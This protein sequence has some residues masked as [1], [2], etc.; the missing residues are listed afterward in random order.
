MDDA[1]RVKLEIAGAEFPSFL[2]QTRIDR[3]TLRAV[4]PERAL[5]EPR[6]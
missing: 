1:V 3:A 5:A 6:I 4:A 2:E